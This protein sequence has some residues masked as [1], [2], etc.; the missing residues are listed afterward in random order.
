MKAIAF[1]LLLTT[2][3][4]CSRPTGTCLVERAERAESFCE[5]NIRESSCRS[6][7]GRF[8][9]ESSTA[10]LVRCKVL[11]YGNYRDEIEQRRDEAG[12]K[13]GDPVVFSKDI[14][15]EELAP[16][17]PPPFEPIRVTRP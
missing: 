13:A 2:I 15:P 1:T 16:P 6:P 9:P 14:P 11:G 7:R 10:G 12:M 4:S 8:F 3:P 5:L 17:A